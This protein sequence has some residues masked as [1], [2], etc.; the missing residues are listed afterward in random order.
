MQCW[1][2]KVYSISV[3]IF[4]DK[5]EIKNTNLNLYNMVYSILIIL[6]SEITN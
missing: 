3:L 4:E 1:L 2:T 5:N 6:Y